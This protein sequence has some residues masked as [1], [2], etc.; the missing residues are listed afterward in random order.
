MEYKKNYKFIFLNFL[1]MIFA[2]SSFN[3]WAESKGN[4][5]TTTVEY[6]TPVAG[7]TLDEPSLQLCILITVLIM[8][9]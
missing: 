3:T 5:I 8:Y 2:L 9:G 7:F 4:I 1:V 6:T